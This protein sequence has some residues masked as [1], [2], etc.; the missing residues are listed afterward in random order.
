MFLFELLDKLDGTWQLT[1]IR[2]S[3]AWGGAIWRAIWDVDDPELAMLK[4]RLHHSRTSLGALLVGINSYV[5][6]LPP[7]DLY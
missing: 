3:D 5:F 2:I 6:S 4:T 1:F 7:I